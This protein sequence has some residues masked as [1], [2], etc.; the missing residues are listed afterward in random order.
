HAYITLVR[1][2]TTLEVALVIGHQAERCVDAEAEC[3]LV[4]QRFDVVTHG[5]ACDGHH[6]TVIAARNRTAR[7]AGADP[8]DIAFGVNGRGT[9]VELATLEAGHAGRV[10]EHGAGVIGGR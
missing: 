1:V 8:V 5:H 9:D 4:V 6:V 2:V 3:D 10:A 7:R